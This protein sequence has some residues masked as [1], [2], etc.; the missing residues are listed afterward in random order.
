M[1]IIQMTTST[2]LVTV[3]S[4]IAVADTVDIIIAS[5]ITSEERE[6]DMYRLTNVVSMNNSY[7][8]R[9]LSCD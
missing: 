3:I 1:I 5:V 4:N 2:I 9:W 7:C 8:D 6:S